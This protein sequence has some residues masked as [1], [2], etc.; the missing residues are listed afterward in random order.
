MEAGLGDAGTIRVLFL[1]ALDLPPESRLEFLSNPGISPGTREEVL[2]LLEADQG[3]ETF[4]HGTVAAERS[5][6]LGVGERFGSFETRSILGHGGMGVVFKAD[7]KPSNVLVTAQGEPKLLDFGIA[8]ALDAAPGGET[9]TLALT[10]EFA[11]PEQARGE[12]PTTATDV[13]GLGGVLYFLLTGQ[14]P[15]SMEGISRS[16]V[17]CAISETPPQP[18]SQLRPELKGDV[19]NILLKALHTEPPRRYRSVRELHKD[20]DRFLDRRPVLATRDGWAYRTKRFLQ[21]HTVTSAAAALAL[22]AIVA[23][24]GYLSTRP[25]APSGVSNRFGHWLT[26][27]SSISK[28]RSAIRPARSRR[29]EWLPLPRVS[30]LPASPPMPARIP[31]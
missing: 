29:G 26:S 2:A 25:T 23:V 18:P 21:R 5:S 10:P 14:P 17:Q 9:R 12:A 1:K 3:S 8:R 28:Q 4:L 7:L 22:I 6:A 31:P 20:L 24:P 13:Y 19:E 30:I 27:L 11:S 16:Q 15:H